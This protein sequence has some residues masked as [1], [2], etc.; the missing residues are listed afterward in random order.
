MPQSAAPIELVRG[1]CARR[2]VGQSAEDDILPLRES[3]I[4]VTAA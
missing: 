2:F 3:P 1:V 4:G